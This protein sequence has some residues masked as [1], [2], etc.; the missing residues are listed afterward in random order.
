MAAAGGITI[1]LAVVGLVALHGVLMTTSHCIALTGG[2]GTRS[3]E[4]KSAVS[5]KL[6]KVEA[7]GSLGGDGTSTGSAALD[8]CC[9]NFQKL[10]DADWL[11]GLEACVG[12]AVC[13]RSR[14]RAFAPHLLHSAIFLA[15]S[16]PKQL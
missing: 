2:T 3:S 12:L 8:L 10:S 7:G 9:P 14:G 11:S 15:Q 5:S 1:V 16:A 4:L 13:G 6:G